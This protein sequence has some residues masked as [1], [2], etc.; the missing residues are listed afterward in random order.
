MRQE[1]RNELRNRKESLDDVSSQLKP[2]VL[3]ILNKTAA[4]L[5]EI[6]NIGLAG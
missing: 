3:N 1:P 4:F 5:D 2:D 6:H